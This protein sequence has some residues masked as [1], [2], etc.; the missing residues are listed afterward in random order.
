MKP[1]TVASPGPW[2]TGSH[3]PAARASNEDGSD[4][5][6]ITAVVIKRIHDAVRILSLKRKA[7]PSSGRSAT[8]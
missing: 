6:C 7:K 4:G 8:R 1:M 5:A 2:A 3:L